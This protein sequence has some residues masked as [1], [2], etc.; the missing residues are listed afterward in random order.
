MKYSGTISRGVRT[1]IIKMGD[2]LASIVV[3][4]VEK[5]VEEANIELQDKDVIAITEAVVGISQGNYAT[6]DQIAKDVSSKFGDETVGLIFPIMSRNRFSMLLKGI[7][8]GC[9]KLV[10]QLSY[11][12]DE[13]GN[14]LISEDALFDSGV[15]PYSDVFTAEEFHKIFPN[16]I[17]QFTGVDYI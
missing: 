5:C 13:V 3:D 16:T 15:N 6:A 2:D 8:R 11:P 17:H 10:I 7:S 4:S 9:K 12:G 14:H 1:P